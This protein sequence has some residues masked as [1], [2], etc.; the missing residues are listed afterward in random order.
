M[1]RL[2]IALSGAGLML[3]LSAAAPAADLEAGKA[4]FARFACASCHG[5]DAKSSTSPSYPILAGQHADYLRHALT[6]YQRGQAGMPASANIRNNAVMGALVTQLTAQDID[7][8]AAWL[9][10]LPSPLAVR[11]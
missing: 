9:S 4:A 1:K 11:R 3:G 2:S 6:A 7:N 8:L 10:S 5:E